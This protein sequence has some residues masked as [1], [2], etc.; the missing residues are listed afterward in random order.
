[1]PR[2]LWKVSS[3][4]TRTSHTNRLTSQKFQNGRQSFESL[5]HGGSRFQWDEIT[6]HDWAR[7]ILK[8]TF[9][10][11][12]CKVAVMKD[13]YNIIDC[14]AISWHNKSVRSLSFHSVPRLARHVQMAMSHCEK[15][16][17]LCF[18][19]SIGTYVYKQICKH[20]IKL[21]NV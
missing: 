17:Y 21:Q 15:H 4:Y 18:V 16:F 19:S 8:Q 9:S 2:R 1:M 5:R 10:S 20:S 7:I 11:L 6:P 13:G 12:S 3:R 14:A